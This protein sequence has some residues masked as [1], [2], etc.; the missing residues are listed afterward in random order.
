MKKQL[1]LILACSIATGIFAGCSHSEPPRRSETS[2]TTAEETTTETTVREQPRYITD[3]VDMTYEFDTYNASPV[4]TPWVLENNIPFSHGNVNMY[5]TE[6]VTNSTHTEVIPGSEIY[7]NVSTLLAPVVR[8]YPAEIDGYTVYEIDYS[9]VFPMSMFV[10]DNSGS[11]Y[12]WRYHDVQYLDYYTGMQYPEINMTSSVDSF[13]VYGD[14]VYNGQTYTVYH[15]SYRDQE[16]SPTETVDGDGGRTLN[17][18]VTFN[19]TDYIII[20]NGY[21]GIVMY[22]YTADDTSDSFEVAYESNTATCYDN[23]VFGDN[24]ELVEDYAFLNICELG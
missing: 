18:T 6:F 20:P 21:D 8:H 3:P 16:S 14:V 4:D 5:F 15:Y 23:T 12:Y 11:N 19:V 10:P 9:M 13:C 24:G 7:N 2:E 22:I 17:M 1:S